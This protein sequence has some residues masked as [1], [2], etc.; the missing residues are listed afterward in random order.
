M[1]SFIESVDSNSDGHVGGVCTC[2]SPAFDEFIYILNVYSNEPPA[3]DGQ[4]SSHAR[5][6][7]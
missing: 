4:E 2:P 1:L 7:P 6:L 3:G 5:H